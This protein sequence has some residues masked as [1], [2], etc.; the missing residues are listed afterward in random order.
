MGYLLFGLVFVFVFLSGPVAFIWC[1]VLNNRVQRLEEE[2]LLWQQRQWEKQWEN[3]PRPHGPSPVFLNA[4]HSAPA[5]A[6]DQVREKAREKAENILD[7]WKRNEA[8]HE[9]AAV[10]PGSQTHP[11][12][13]VF[14][15]VEA[16]KPAVHEP[17][18]VAPAAPVTLSPDAQWEKTVDAPP[19]V[20]GSF[21]WQ[22]AELWIGRHLLGWVA[23]GAFI[24]AATFLIHYAVVEG[25]IGRIPAPFKVLGI[26]A[27]GGVFLVAGKYFSLQGW[28]RFSTMLSSAGII[29]VF[30]AGYASFGFYELLSTTTAG[31][32]MSF[33]V[34]GSFLLSWHYE[35]KLLGLISILGGL[36]VPLLLSTGTDHYPAFFTYLVILNLGVV[37]LVNLLKRAPLGLLAFVGTQIEFWLWHGEYYVHPDK[38]W[39]ALL[40]QSAI[41]LVYLFDT[42]IASSI[43]FRKGEGK[44][45]WDDATRAILAPIVFFGVI[46]V[47]LRND[48]LL[49]EW[50]GIFAFI[51]AA[52]YALLAV[53][54]GKHVKRLWDEDADQQLSVYWKAGPTAATVMALSFVAIGIPLHF[55]A[56]WFA[57]GWTSVFAGLWYFGNRQDHKAFRVMSAVFAGLGLIRV[58]HDIFQFRLIII[59]GPHLAP[60]PVLNDFAL[61]PLAVAAI[62]IFVT[63][64]V[65]RLAV[66]K[67]GDS[68]QTQNRRMLNFAAGLIGFFALCAVLSVESN[69]FFSW[70]NELYVPAA[71]WISL[72]LTVLWTI[73]ATALAQTGFLFRSKDLRITALV[74]FALVAVKVFAVDCIGRCQAEFSL[75]NPYSVG[76]LIVSLLFVGQGVQSC[77]VKNLED[78]ER[79]AWGVLGVAGIFSLLA[80]LSIECFDYFQKNPFVAEPR[81]LETIRLVALGTLSVL[82]TAYAG[83]LLILGLSFKSCALRNCGV[84]VFVATL[85][86]ILA[87]E[88][89]RRPDYPVAFANPYFLCILCPALAVMLLA[90]WTAWFR[91]LAG[92]PE[93]YVHRALGI[94]GILLLW[95]ILSVECFVHFDRNPFSDVWS[96]DT[97]RRFV[98]SASLSLLWSAL[99]ATLIVFGIANRSACLRYVGVTVLA[100]AVV[101]MVALEIFCRP[102]FETA[103]L[104]PYFL[105][106]FV[107]S[108][109]MMALAAWTTRIKPLENR[110]EKQGFLALGLVAV[111]LVW[112]AASVECSEYFYIRT[113]WPNHEFLASA[114]LTVFWTV[115]AVVLAI[116]AAALRSK[117]LRILSVAL[118]L[119]TVLK[120]GPLDLLARPLYDTPFLNPYALP[121]MALAFSVVLVSLWHAG[122]LSAE[123]RFERQAYRMLIFAGIVFLWLVMSLECFKSVRL[124]QDAA[125]EAWKAQMALSILWS[126]FSGVLIFIGFVCRSSSLR[127]MAILLF[128]LTSAKVLIVDMAGVHELYR[129]GAFF[130]LAVFLMLA[131]W[132]YQRFRPERTDTD[133]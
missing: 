89:I 114:A 99:A 32:V 80:I 95:I 104:N 74:C 91:P 132:A 33:I 84:A 38:L 121:L 31:L 88:L 43:P 68:E 59:K 131:A 106:I 2:K 77:L 120:V 117:A 20:D 16:P 127:W 100:A 18:M 5:P 133:K 24:L 23:V 28:R 55:D 27:F 76:L 15:P 45:T 93:R 14:S 108:V 46:W 129:F 71:H 96:D 63:V 30:Q 19:P 98:A 60:W 92:D 67:S 123:D 36:A 48:L 22:A 7:V 35:S 111:T 87:L 3:A 42:T 58:L 54:Y 56:A 12:P 47:L 57:L 83:L 70:R 17:E 112:A 61:P 8:I 103:L 44:P 118:L 13:P 109:L 39:P 110:S 29:I 64:L 75:L 116:I 37:M 102:D 51:G 79:K 126:V 40:F 25:W 52:W 119:I 4:V 82:W 41:Y 85:F 115:L 34:A 94:A 73:L 10:S 1:W 69:Y 11:I 21:S 26:A 86:K 101:K 97:T 128:A 78:E 90:V 9:P 124:L 130:V 6:M 66:L 81:N 107:P 49:K 65:A 53:V 72:S 50:L 125:E 113:D 105:S 62:T 122:G